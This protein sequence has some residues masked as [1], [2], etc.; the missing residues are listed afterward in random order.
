MQEMS[1]QS[2]TVADLR[3]L[4]DQVCGAEC[5]YVR[6]AGDIPNGVISR[7]PI[8]ASGEWIDPKVSNRT[9]V[10]AR[11]DVPGSADL[12]AISVHLLT[13]DGGYRP[14]EAASLIDY[15]RDNISASDYIVLGGDL[16]TDLRDESAIGVL[17]NEFTIRDTFPTD[18]LGNGNTSAPRSKPYDWVLASPTL[19]PYEVP[20]RIG[21]VTFPSGAVIDTR[22]F[23]PIAD[24][25]PAQIGDSGAGGMQHMAVARD[26]VL[27]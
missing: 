13:A 11:I 2:G 8:L 19:D 16:N 7:N 27:P 25:A 23:T 10:W 26:F 22:V 3:S 9:F 20:L 6:G 21:S 12:W 5:G 24:L 1:Y 18:Q 15:I 17:A 4:V 14:A